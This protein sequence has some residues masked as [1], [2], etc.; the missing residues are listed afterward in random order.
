MASGSVVLAERESEQQAFLHR[1]LH[2]DGFAVFDAPLSGH[3]LDIVE[4]LGP[5]A[6]I[7]TEHDFCRRLRAGEPGRRWNRNVPVLFLAE[8]SSTALDRV[9][10]LESGADDVVAQ[11]V[12][13]ELVARLR[14]LLRRAG[15]GADLVHAG[16][17][18]VDRRAR[19]VRVLGLAV[20]LTG[21]EYDL[22]EKL[23]SDP[24]RTFSKAELLRDVWGI[25]GSVRTRTLDSHACRLRLKLEAAGAEGVVANVWG[26]GY[27]LL[28]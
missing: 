18:T 14:A 19:S 24:C 6:V 5:D 27:R 16:D 28:E 12:Y 13:P 25:R 23:A 15:L 1:N 22:A 17:V 20:T 21:R 11:D 3:A 26:V 10:A 8:P 2:A 7:A 9:R 4:R